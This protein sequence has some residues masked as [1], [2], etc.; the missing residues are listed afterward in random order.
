MGRAMRITLEALA[1][2]TLIGGQFAAAIAMTAVKRNYYPNENGD[3][4]PQ[5][6]KAELDRFHPARPL[7][8]WLI[9]S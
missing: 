8:Q 3:L 2:A 6:T 5:S 9:E 7:G 4:P 1:F